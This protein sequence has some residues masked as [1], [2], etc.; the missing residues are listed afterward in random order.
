MRTTQVEIADDE[1]FTGWLK[2][3]YS[4]GGET[5]DC[6]EVASGYASVPVRDSK[7]ATG[8]VVVFSAT[9]WSTFLGAVKS[10]SL[11]A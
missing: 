1:A 8:P 7:N 2:S 11:D 5:S 9:G 3:A 10:G 6:L 4:G